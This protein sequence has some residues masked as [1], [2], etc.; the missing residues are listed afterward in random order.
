M[1][2]L[3]FYFNIV[4]AVHTQKMFLFFY[5]LK[6]NT[7]RWQGKHW[8]RKPSQQDFQWHINPDKGLRGEAA[9]RENAKEDFV[10]KLFFFYGFSVFPFRT[11]KYNKGYAALSQHAEDTLVALDSDR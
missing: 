10:M 6:K 5:Y 1:L 8:K 4:S 7:G 11:V 3:S 2:L 9:W